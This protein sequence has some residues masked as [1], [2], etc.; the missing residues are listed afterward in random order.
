MN[1]GGVDS[2]MGIAC[3]LVKGLIQPALLIPGRQAF[4]IGAEG[5]GYAA[6]AGLPLVVHIEHGRS[7][8][9]GGT[10]SA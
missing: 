7:A 10:Q 9:E 1:L 5:V 4:Q 8:P 3:L 6:E 2:V